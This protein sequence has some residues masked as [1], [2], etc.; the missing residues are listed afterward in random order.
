[1]IL[2]FSDPLQADV[3]F[4]AGRRIVTDRASRSADD[5]IKRQ[6]K[7]A[8]PSAYRVCEFVGIQ[9]RA[10]LPGNLYFFIPSEF[11]G[12]VPKAQEDARQ[13]LE[14]VSR[15]LRILFQQANPAFFR[16]YFSKLVTIAQATF[17]PDSFRPQ[18][19]N[20]ID[21]LKQEVVQ[22]T[23]GRIK[24]AYLK[25]MAL[26]AVGAAALIVAVSFGAVWIGHR[27]SENGTVVNG[28]V[29][30]Y[31]RWDGGYS[32]FHTGLTLAA[33]MIGVLFATTI[34]NIEPTF[35][36]LAQEGADLMPPWLKLLFAGIV[37][38]VLALLFET[39]VI[40]VTIGPF[41]TSRISEDAFTAILV[42][43]FVGM[44]DKELVPEIKRWGRR[45]VLPSARQIDRQTRKK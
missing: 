28:E 14:V 5:A 29:P 17:D 1:M 10:D 22:N 16:E 12:P 26:W 33:S 3:L 24:S 36:T 25:R 41:S 32:I 34:R 8:A 4:A 7:S 19:L 6:R 43:F 11:A 45:L 13:E 44:L 31:V 39:K 9:G 42:G 40:S 27:L 35:E 38:L 2:A 20:D 15:L 37:S 21:N 23:A 18:A 30:G